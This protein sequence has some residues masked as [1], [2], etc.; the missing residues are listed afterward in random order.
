MVPRPQINTV[1]PGIHHWALVGAVLVVVGDVRHDGEQVVA[2]GI[3][4]FYSTFFS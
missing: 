1:G 2:A 4:K 3:S